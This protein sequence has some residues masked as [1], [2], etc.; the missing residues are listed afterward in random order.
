MKSLIWALGLLLLASCGSLPAPRY[1]M[2]PSLLERVGDATVALIAETTDEDRPYRIYCSGVFID[3]SHILTAH[4]CVDDRQA[5]RVG[6]HHDA[7]V[8]ENLFY[9]QHWRSYEVSARD[10]DHDLALLEYND[11]RDQVPHAVLS[12]TDHDPLVGENVIVSGH[13]VGLAWT[14]TVGPVSVPRRQGWGTNETYNEDL[15]YMQH[16][17]PAFYGNS[18]GPVVDFEGRIVGIISGGVPGASHLVM[19][20]HHSHLREFVGVDE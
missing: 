13:P 8:T 15:L 17:A 12:I 11:Y 10:E 20:I 18:G 1:V 4:H 2:S 16:Q 5:V 14:Y 6:T 3:D 7:S 19:S 9:G